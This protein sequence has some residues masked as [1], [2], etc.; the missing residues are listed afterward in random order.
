MLGEGM[1]IKSPNRKNKKCF[2]TT[3]ARSPLSPVA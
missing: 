3:P 1:F 2:P